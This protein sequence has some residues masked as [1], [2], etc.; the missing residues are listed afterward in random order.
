MFSA[1][2]FVLTVVHVTPV[3]FPLLLIFCD[4][5][6]FFFK[7]TYRADAPKHIHLLPICQFKNKSQ[8]ADYLTGDL[9]KMG[10]EIDLHTRF[11]LSPHI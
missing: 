2:I 11:V 10:R 1:L 6:P 5:Q 7:G 8:T 3:L 4:Q 9:L